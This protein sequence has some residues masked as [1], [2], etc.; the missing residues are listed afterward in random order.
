MDT[1]PTESVQTP[2]KLGG[3]LFV[4]FLYVVWRPIQFVVFLLSMAFS[5]QPAPTSIDLILQGILALYALL[6]ARMLFQRRWNAILHLKRFIWVWLGVA[7]L[8]A[9]LFSDRE[10]S[11]SGLLLAVVPM[12]FCYGYLR[13]SKRV[14]KTFPTDPF[15]MRVSAGRTE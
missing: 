6:C 15:V 2:P 9:F 10:P 3:W 7:L 11:I 8:N 1:S 12:L 4:V 13:F 14:E 5:S